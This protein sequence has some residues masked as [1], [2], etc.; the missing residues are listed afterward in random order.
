[1]IKKGLYIMSGLWCVFATMIT[2]I[3]LSLTYLNLS[4]EIYQYDYSMDEGTAV[5]FGIVM[6]FIW[7]LLA[8]LPVF[9]LMKQIRKHSCKLFY[10]AIGIIS[11]FLLCSVVICKGNIVDFLKLINFL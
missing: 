5:V 1:M 11:L 8:V 7:L 4:G 9:F 3:W 6:M 10:V 2:P